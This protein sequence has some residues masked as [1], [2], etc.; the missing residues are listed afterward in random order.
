M[1]SIDELLREAVDASERFWFVQALHIAERTDNTI[2]LHLQI[3]DEMFIQIFFSQRSL[4]LSFALINS[5]GRIYGRDREHG[6]WHRHPF[7][8][9]HKHEP[10]PEGMS[11]RPLTQFLA[12][13][14]E[15]LLANGLI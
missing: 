2:T 13:T 5:A 14:E 10:T 1:T 4:R 8:Q 15:L 11:S 6:L 9:P 7:G 12:E 3:T